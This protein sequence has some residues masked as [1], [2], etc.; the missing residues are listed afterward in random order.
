MTNIQVFII[1]ALARY[2]L[3]QPDKLT[4]LF[5][6]KAGLTIILALLPLD[7]IKTFMNCLL[8]MMIY[9]KTTMAYK[10]YKDKSTG[11]LAGATLWMQFVQFSG[12]IFT[13]VMSGNNGFLPPMLLNW[14]YQTVYVLQY[15]WY[16]RSQG[17][18]E[19]KKKE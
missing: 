16:S 7:Y 13:T 3:N 17:K 1:H 14:S 15:L 6:G 9:N 19:E 8:P 18:E 11:Q 10:H 12:R 5:L 4:I 2:Y